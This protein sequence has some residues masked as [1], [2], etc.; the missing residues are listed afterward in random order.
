MKLRVSTVIESQ[1]SYIRI[2][3]YDSINEKLSYNCQIQG[4]IVI[5]GSKLKMSVF[6]IPVDFQSH[7]PSLRNTIALNKTRIAEVNRC[8]NP[9][10]R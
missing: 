3:T 7:G 6:S 9:Q 2:S 8:L 4:I 10:Q 1:D 5:C